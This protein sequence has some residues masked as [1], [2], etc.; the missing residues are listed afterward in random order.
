MFL[1]I[2]MFIEKWKFI[3]K[4][5]KMFYKYGIFVYWL[6]VYLME[7]V[8]YFGLKLFFVMLLILVIFVIW[9]DGYEE[10]YIYVVCV[11]LG[12]Y[13]LGLLVDIDDLVNKMFNG[14]LML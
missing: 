10:E 14:E 12:D 3:V 5:G 9:I 6:E 4:F 11:D 8:I 13:D 1:K 2:V 7:V